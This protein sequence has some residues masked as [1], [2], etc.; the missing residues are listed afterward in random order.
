M[1][2]IEQKGVP[3]SVAWSQV[4]HLHKWKRWSADC[5]RGVGVLWLLALHYDGRLILG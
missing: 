5:Q 3:K 2:A 1:P 4:E